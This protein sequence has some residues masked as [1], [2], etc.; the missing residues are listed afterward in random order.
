MLGL[1]C[2]WGS[3]ERVLDNSFALVGGMV[4]IIWLG[5]PQIVQRALFPKLE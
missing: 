3:W 5:L 4:Y 1:A 2:A